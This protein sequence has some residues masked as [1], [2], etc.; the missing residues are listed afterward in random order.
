MAKYIVRVSGKAIRKVLQPIYMAV[1]T[2]G[3]WLRI[4]YEFNNYCKNA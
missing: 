1:A 3:E 2:T 4:A